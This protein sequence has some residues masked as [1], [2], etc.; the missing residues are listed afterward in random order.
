MDKLERRLK[1]DAERIRAEVTPEMQ[2]RIDAALRAAKPL[3]PV[4][5]ARQQVATLWWA[6]SLTGLAAAVALIVLLNWNRPDA[7]PEPLAPVANRTVPDGVVEQPYRFPLNARTADLTEPLEE[8]LEHLQEDLEKARRNME[9]DLDF[10][11]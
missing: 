1:D 9:R 4:P 7:G 11:F 10:T 8:E 2:A 5:P 3:R 6:S